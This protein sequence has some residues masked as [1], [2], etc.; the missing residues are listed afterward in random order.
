LIV[1]L[2]LGHGLYTGASG[3]EQLFRELLGQDAG[4]GNSSKAPSGSSPSTAP[5]SPVPLSPSEARAL[6]RE[7]DVAPAGSMVGYSR[8]DFP[9]WAAD[10]TQFGWD[11]PDGSCDVRNDALVRDGHGVKVDEECSITAGE[12]LDPYTGIT[13]TDSKDVDIDH[14]VPLANA[15]RSGANDW[16]ESRR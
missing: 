2:V 8:E 6:R 4:S 10:G 11:E 13:L 5:G 12:W 7:L 9:H 16:D 15:W 14:V 3:P 1:V